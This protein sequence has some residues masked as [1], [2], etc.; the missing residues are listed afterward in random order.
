[1][2]PDAQTINTPVEVIELEELFNHVEVC[3]IRGCEAEAEWVLL[4]DCC[5]SRAFYCDPH[6]VKRQQSM[7]QA[8][9]RGYGMVHDRCG[10][11]TK[12]FEWRPV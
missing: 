2:E 10:R 9:S 11:V 12:N 7:L 3:V 1:M 5:P 6:R 8:K 4:P